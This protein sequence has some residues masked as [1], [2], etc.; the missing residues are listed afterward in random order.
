MKMFFLDL[1]MDA[2][3]V[4]NCSAS[5]CISTCIKSCG[6]RVQ[7][8]VNVIP[9]LREIGQHDVV[10]DAWRESSGPVPSRAR[11]ETAQRNAFVSPGFSIAF[12]IP[13]SSTWC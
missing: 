8:V 3:E 5:A 7:R 12:R 6:D 1:W 9:T 13:R 10:V 11:R 4:L 2:C